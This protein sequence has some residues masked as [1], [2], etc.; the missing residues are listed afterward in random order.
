MN[1]F[2]TVLG[3]DGVRRPENDELWEKLKNARGE[4]LHDIPKR[5]TT[6]H[7][8][9]DKGVYC[10]HDG[11]EAADGCAVQ[12]RLCVYRIERDEDGGNPEIFV[13]DV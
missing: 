1:D 12:T 3:A 9:Y 4:D 10:S 7:N 11:R 2:L 13:E 5:I 6:W 8:V